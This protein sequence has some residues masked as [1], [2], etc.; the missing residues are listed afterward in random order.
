MV[1][2]DK[3]FGVSFIRASTR[4]GGTLHNTLKPAVMLASYSGLLSTCFH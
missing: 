2:A 1:D 4:L 3:G